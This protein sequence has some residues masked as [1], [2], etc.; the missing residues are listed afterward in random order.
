MRN[1]AKSRIEGPRVLLRPMRNGDFAAWREVRVRNKAWLDPWEPRPDAGTTDPSVDADAYRARCAA[2]DRQRQFDAAHGFGLFLVDGERFIGEVSLG[3][4]QRGPFQSAQL[5]YW[6]DEEYAGRGFVPEGVALVLRFAFDD[7][8]LHRIEV[9]IVP[10]NVAS[11]KVAEKL[12]LRS[13][14]TAERFLQ[15]N[16]VYED[17]ARYAITSEEW[18]VKRTKIEVGYLT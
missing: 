7:L 18:E 5:G 13:E 14:G 4:V 6:I 8:R 3:S 11:R 1:N 16:G 2:W 15:I 10:R 9:A 17:H 12:G